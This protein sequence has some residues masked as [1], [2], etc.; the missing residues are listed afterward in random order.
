M[1]I[2]ELREKLTNMPDN[3]IVM[4]DDFYGFVDA[5]NAEYAD[6]E[7]RLEYCGDYDQ[8]V[9]KKCRHCPSTNAEYL[10]KAFIIY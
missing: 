1:T 10:G 5:E 8:Y 3:T 2:K 6:I 7:K 4:I 9:V